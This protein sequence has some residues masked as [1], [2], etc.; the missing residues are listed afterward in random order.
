MIFR[1]SFRIILKTP[2][3]KDSETLFSKFSRYLISRICR[4]VVI[5]RFGTGWRVI[6]GGLVRRWF[7]VLGTWVTGFEG[8]DLGGGWA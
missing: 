3:K 8:F 7:R 6:S 4:K 2:F 1:T 5:M